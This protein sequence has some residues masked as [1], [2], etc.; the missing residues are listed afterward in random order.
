MS[1]SPIERYRAL[2]DAGQLQRDRAQ[3]R[4]AE[5]LEALYRTLKS[6]R[7][8]SPGIFRFAF[9]GNEAAPPK[10]L[11]IHGDVGRGKSALMD[12]FYESASI[13]PKRRV[14]FNQFMTETHQRIHE[15]RNL[16]QE[17]KSRLPKFLR[18]AEDDPIAPVAKRILSEATLLCLDEFQVTDVADAMILGRLFEKLFSLGVIIVL[19]SNTAPDDLYQDGLNRQL[20]LPF[21]ALIK[22]RL[23]MIEL[24]GPRDY[25]LDGMAG[26]SVYNTPL[27]PEAD[28][29]MDAAWRRL[30][31]SAKAESLTLDV[32]ERKIP[33]PQAAGRVARFSFEALCGEALGAADY[34]ALAQRFHTLLI[35]HIPRL[36]PEQSNEA[37]RFTLLIDT[38][39]DEKV[40]LVVSAAS[41]PQELYTEGENA[42]AFRR[43]AS[44]LVEMQSEDYLRTSEGPRIMDAAK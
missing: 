38:L 14:H 23:E 29:A 8:R 28:A 19:T 16:P 42:Q 15:W 10:G 5:A 39:Y 6:Y 41:P 18:E 1:Q 40:K 36:E 35:D 43:A 17:E 31:G 22:E 21:I 24:N 34:L 33:V 3:A 37:R 20:F 30:T 9:G 32:L 7:P 26:V 44:R 11:Y 13:A 4:A 12:M 25:R 2:L 27:G